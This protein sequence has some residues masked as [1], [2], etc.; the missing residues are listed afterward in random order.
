MDSVA[1]QTTVHGVAKSQTKLSDFHFYLVRYLCEMSCFPELQ[2]VPQGKML[3]LTHTAR[4][5]ALI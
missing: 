5:E 2:K 4:I 1:W 3:G